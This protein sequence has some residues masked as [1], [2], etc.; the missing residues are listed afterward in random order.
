MLRKILISLL[1][2]ITSCSSVSNKIN[3]DLKK[4]EF[5]HY[6]EFLTSMNKF[7]YSLNVHQKLDLFLPFNDS[8]RISN[9]CYVFAH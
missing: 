2:I 9:F 8:Y 3:Y 7:T 1:F 6:Q 5:H 4:L